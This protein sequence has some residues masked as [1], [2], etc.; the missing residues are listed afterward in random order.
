MCLELVKSLTSALARY[1][2][3]VSTV[4]GTPDRREPEFALYDTTTATV[5]I[6]RCVNDSITDGPTEKKSWIESLRFKT[7]NGN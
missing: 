4:T 2:Q 7:Q 1:L 6:Y 3:D 5:N